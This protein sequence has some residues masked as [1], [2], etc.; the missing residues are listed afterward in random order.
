M[1]GFR[2]RR[3]GGT[4]YGSSANWTALSRLVRGGPAKLRALLLKQGEV[5]RIGHGLIA[6]IIRMKTIF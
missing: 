6:G 5:D 4:L 1:I 2:C 3:T